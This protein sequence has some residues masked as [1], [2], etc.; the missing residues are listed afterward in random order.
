MPAGR[1]M[2]TSCSASRYPAIWGRGRYRGA[3]HEAR[4]RDA[5]RDDPAA[6]R[7]LGH[8]RRAAGG[9]TRAFSRRHTRRSSRPPDVSSRRL[10]RL[11]PH[12][13]SRTPSGRRPWWDERDL[14]RSDTAL[15]YLS[16][17]RCVQRTSSRRRPLEPRRRHQA[18]ADPRASPAR[19]PDAHRAGGSGVAAIVQ[20]RARLGRGVDPRSRT[21]A[22][23]ACRPH[24][25]NATSRAAAARGR[26]RTPAAAGAIARRHLS[27][28]RGRPVRRIVG[29]G[30]SLRLGRAGRRRHS[31]LSGP[32]GAECG[33]GEGSLR[34]IH[35]VRDGPPRALPR[36]SHLPL[37]PVPSH[38][39]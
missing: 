38:R 4:A 35:R 12:G 2:R 31:D 29:A 30:I 17:V 24:D 13:P 39:R 15:R 1:A 32:V 11:L 23:T 20:A 33:S 19:G 16:L 22:C 9:T 6:M 21:S 34:S 7:L 26:T 37:R 28:L 18:P 5:R 27:R 14:P 36:S 10:R 8:G 25:R 3:G